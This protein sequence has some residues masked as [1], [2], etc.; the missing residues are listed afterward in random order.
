MIFPT[1]KTGYRLSGGTPFAECVRALPWLLH[2][3]VFGMNRV[4]LL[5]PAGSQKNNN[6]QAFRFVFTWGVALE[7]GRL[8]ASVWKQ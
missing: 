1:Q 6:R 2:Y 3:P 4:L 5:D 7:M 8:I